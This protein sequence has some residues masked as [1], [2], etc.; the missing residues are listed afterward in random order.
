MAV[1]IIAGLLFATGLSM[2]VLPVV[3]T[4]VFGISPDED[5]S[6]GIS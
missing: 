6:T 1:T 4:V 3:Y 2:V 5:Q